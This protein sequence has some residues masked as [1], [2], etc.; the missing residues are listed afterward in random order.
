MANRI[1]TVAIIGGGPG[2]ASLGALLAREGYTV[3]IF[4]SDKRP[5]LIVGESLLP[6]VVPMLRTLGIEDEVKSFSVHKPGATVCLAVDE[7][8]TALFRWADGRLPDYAYNTPRDLF[9][10]AVLNAAERAGARIFKTSAGLEKG[11]VA[12]AVRLSRETLEKTGGCFSDQPDLI[13]DGSGRTR[14]ISKLLEA[15]V[16]RGGRDDVALFAHLS[17]AT[18]TDPGNIHIDHLSKGWSWRIPLPGRVSVGI[19]INPKHLEKYGSGIE[20]QY[21]SYIRDEPSLKVYTEGSARLTPVVKYR[22]YQLISGK[23]SG[24]G[25]AMVG[26]A[27]GFIDPVFSTGLYLSMKGAFKL[28]D[29]IQSGTA[30]AMRTYEKAMNWEFRHW[31]RVIDSWYNGRLFNSYRVGQKQ[32]ALPFGLRVEAHVQKHLVR[33][34]T[35]QAVEDFYSRR[36]FGHLT[37]VSALMRSPK[38]LVVM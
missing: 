23:M 22:N 5:P 37:T 9:D 33:I 7:V 21:D 25:W 36:L 27:A 20:T 11:D 28:F 17:K 6:A 13:V 26:D 19:V 32:K 24:P 29:A 2:G 35:G 18:I 16:K 8:I 4:H 31:R 34:F 15:P 38:D 12:G 3:G 10:A 14:L 1:R 30:G